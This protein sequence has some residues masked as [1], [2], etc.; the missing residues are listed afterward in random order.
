VAL[1]AVA[2]ESAHRSPPA[3]GQANGR[4]GY[5]GSLAP[6]PY[7]PR[8]DLDRMVDEVVVTSRSRNM[9]RRCDRERGLNAGIGSSRLQL[10]S[11]SAVPSDR[12]HDTAIPTR[13]FVHRSISPTRQTR[14]SSSVLAVTSPVQLPNN[15]YVC[16]CRHYL[17]D[18]TVEYRFNREIPAKSF[19]PPIYLTYCFSC[20]VTPAPLTP[21]RYASRSVKGKPIV[22]LGRKAN[23]SNE[24]WIAKP[25]K[26]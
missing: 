9:S 14:F 8:S 13:I 6:S 12:N 5:W 16:R 4:R 2:K 19:F 17:I 15:R 24:F 23:G 3:R 1:I 18:R 7:Q 21:S 26:A 20:P 11:G 10:A 25:P 22:R